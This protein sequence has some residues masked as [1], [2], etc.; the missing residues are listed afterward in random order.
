MK[1]LAID[2]ASNCGWC[3]SETD[4][5]TWDFNTRKDESSGMKW[6]RFRAKLKE[7]NDLLKIDLIAYER[8]A[9][10]HK[11]SIIHSAKMVAIIE[12]FCEENGIQYRAFSASE[13]KKFATGKGGAGKPAMIKAAKDKYG[14]DG[15]DDNTA[16]AIHIYFLA[17]D[18][19]NL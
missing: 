17:K 4:Y 1:I 10:H 13:I 2:Q 18:S 8:V 14:Y 19:L 3:V 5:G 12:S 15:N 6:L 9:G 16:D 11:N 7:M